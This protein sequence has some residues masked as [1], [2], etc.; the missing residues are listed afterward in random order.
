LL[1][2]LLLDT[3]YREAPYA[4]LAG[5]EQHLFADTAAL[6]AGDLGAMRHLVRT[7]VLSG[8]GMTICHGSYPAS[9]GEHLISHY[10]DMMGPVSLAPAFHG[11]QIAVSTA[12]MA[13]IQTR[14]LDLERVQIGPTKID[15]EAVL[16]HFGPVVGE[17]CWREFSQKQLDVDAINARLENWEAIRRRIAAISVRGEAMRALLVAAGAPTT[18]GD[19]GWPVELYDNAVA[20]AREI[21]SRFTF[22]DLAGDHLRD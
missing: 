17:S 16:A 19:L 20:H 8:F 22:L 4:L 7:L 3:P 5:D 15:R 9:Q 12:T 10:I 18:P 2:H 21:R 13:E 11:E 1:S 14:L 6:L